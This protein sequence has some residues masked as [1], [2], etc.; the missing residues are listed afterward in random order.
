M[1]AEHVEGAVAVTNDG[2]VVHGPIVQRDR[3]GIHRRIREVEEATGDGEREAG[4]QCEFP[5]FHGSP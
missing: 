2:R 1:R 5:E 4:A 3:G